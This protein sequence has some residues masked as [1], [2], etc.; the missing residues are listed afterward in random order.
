MI[1]VDTSAWIEFFND[2]DPSVVALVDQ[3]LREELVVI[4]DL[5][6]CEIL[7][8]LHNPQERRMIADILL[9]LPQFD[10]VGFPLA[11]KA[12]NNYRHLRSRGLTIRKTIDVLIATFCIEYEMELIHHDRDFTHF[13]SELGLRIRG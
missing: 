12:A 3:A 6:Y 7:Q 11:E 10:L 2:G 4:G 9:A 5:V 8:G 13:A 1:M